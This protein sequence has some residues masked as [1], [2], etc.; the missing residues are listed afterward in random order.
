MTLRDDIKKA[1][2]TAEEA[3]TLRQDLRWNVQPG[4]KHREQAILAQLDAIRLAMVPIRAAMGRLQFGSISATQE[5]KLR[6]VSQR[7]QY[8]RRQLKKMRRP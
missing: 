7:L 3:E 2:E 4:E 5:A 1:A 6:A 8:E